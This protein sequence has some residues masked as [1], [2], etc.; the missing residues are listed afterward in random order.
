[1]TTDELRRMLE[2][3]ARAQGI[4][5][6]VAGS[7]PL[8]VSDSGIVYD[9]L[10]DDGDSARMRSALLIDVDWLVEIEEGMGFL[11]QRRRNSG[12]DAFGVMCWNDKSTHEL[13]ADHNGDRNAALRLCALR[14]AA[15]IGEGM[16]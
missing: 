11:T 5:G 16:E 1:M 12:G 13:F 14:V 3:A 15:A 7:S 4:V 2:L 10:D 8:F 6:Q 9:W